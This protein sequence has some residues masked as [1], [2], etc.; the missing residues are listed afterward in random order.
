MNRTLA[1]ALAAVA[2]SAL[3][4]AD[5]AD[6]RRLGGGRSLG[7]QRQSVAP[8]PT[9]PPAA[10]PSAPGGAASNPVM[11]AQQGA[12]ASKAAP[13]TPAAAPASG[14]SR[15]LGPIAG[16]AAGLGLAA[17]AAHLGMSEMLMNVILIAL[18]A[19]AAIAIL[20]FVLARRAGAR[21]PVAYAPATPN[22]FRTPSESRVEPL[23]GVPSP[24]A[25]S[26]AATAARPRASDRYP[27][28]FDPVPFLEQARQQFIRLQGAYDRG[29][30]AALADVMTPDLFADVTREL[31]ARGGH[32]ATEVVAL[33]P[34]IAEVTT[35]GDRHWASVRFRGLLR[36]DGAPFPKPLDE[37]WNLTKPADGSSGWLLAGIR[38]LDEVPPGHA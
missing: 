26:T 17:L 38:Q 9:T 23:L 19:F 28:G 32:V 25:S 22:T 29:D 30:R 15:W 37:L 4:S 18:L 20:R 27:A 8:A 34:E 36:E 7:A 21:G 13:A 33:N 31:D 5:F 16:L 11:P 24:V 2:T 10:A 35:E 3:L 12:A 6:A 14:A 1:V